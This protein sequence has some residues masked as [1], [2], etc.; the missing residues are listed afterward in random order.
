M[1]E[2]DPGLRLELWTEAPIEQL[3]AQ[4]EAF[5][6]ERLKVK[7]KSDSSSLGSSHMTDR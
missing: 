5:L 7:Q 2:I 1:D 4:S 6:R 3:V